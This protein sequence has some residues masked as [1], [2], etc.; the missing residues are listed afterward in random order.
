MRKNQNIYMGDKS[1]A[2]L[3]LFGKVDT[4]N[5]IC[6][7]A[8]A[9]AYDAL[10]QKMLTRRLGVF[11]QATLQ[12]INGRF[13]V[14]KNLCIKYAP[15]KLMIINQ[16]QRITTDNFKGNLSDR[17]AVMMLQEIT[18]RYNLD[19]NMLNIAASHVNQA[20][21]MQPITFNPFGIDMFLWLGDPNKK[22]P[23]L[24]KRKRG[25]Y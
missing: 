8:I 1:T 24:R 10:N 3:P 20:E 19:P 16:I 2:K 25:R 4:S 15:D 13:Q 22:T 5:E 7:N 17:Q 9:T 21:Q 18:R 14:L 6:L 11:N 12:M 23:G